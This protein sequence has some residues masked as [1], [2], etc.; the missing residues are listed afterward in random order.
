MLP[1]NRSLVLFVVHLFS[2]WPKTGNQ[3]HQ[4]RASKMGHG[5]K[6]LAAKLNNQCSIPW[7]YMVEEN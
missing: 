5:V 3:N 7:A 6:G 4:W 1:G 2:P